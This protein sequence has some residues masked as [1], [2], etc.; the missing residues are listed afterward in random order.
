[1][2]SSKHQN[3]TKIS[4]DIIKEE[5]IKLDISENKIKFIK[6]TIENNT[7]EVIEDSKLKKITSWRKSKKK[8]LNNLIYNILSLG[9]LHI[10]SLFY[11]NLYLKLYCNPWPPKECDFFLVEN[12]YGELTLCTKIQKKAKNSVIDYNSEIIKQNTLSSSSIM[13][14]NQKIDYYLTKNLTYSFKYKSVI[15][16]Y[17]EET[18]EIIP[19][20]M[21]LSS[22]TKKGIFNYFSEG[23][24]SDNLVKKFQD[25][26]G[27]NEYNLN[28]DLTILYSKNIEIYYFIFI[29]ITKAF[30]LATLDYYSFFVSIFIIILMIL[31]EYCIMKKIVYDIYKKEYTLDGEGY[32]LR[33]KRKHKFDNNSNFYYEINNCELLPG[34]IIYL[35]AN[36]YVPCDC[37]ILEGECIVNES[38][39]TGKLDIYKKSNLENSNEQFNYNSNKI[40]ILYHGMKIVKTYSNLKEQYISALCINTGP[41]TY[42]A[43]QYSNILY[44]LERKV[45]YKKV[46]TLMGEGRKTTFIFMA[47]I[48]FFS[49]FLGLFYMYNV[50]KEFNIEVI[51]KLLFKIIAKL[52]TKSFMPVFYIT[53]T[54]IIMISII[55]LKNENIF[56][57][58]K[59][60]LLQS[61]TINT[62]FFGKT[63]T[64]CENNFEIYGYHPIYVNPHRSN[65]ITYTTFNLSQTKEMNSQLLNYYKYYLY[66]SQ[67]SNNPHESNLRHGF[68]LDNNLYKEKINKESYEYTALF[69]ECL[70]SCNNLEKY[71]IEI[72]GNPI[73]KGIFSNMRW[74]IKT[75]SFNNIKRGELL[76]DDFSNEMEASDNHYYFD[77]KFII[78][79][80]IDDIYPKNYY[81]ITESLKKDAE[82]HHKPLI[83]K[84]NSKYY[85]NQSKKNV[86]NCNSSKNASNS[87]LKS[88]NYIKINVSRSH[89]KSYKLRI[90]KRFISGNLNSSSIVYNFIT[91]ELRFMT[92]GM[93]EDILDKCDVNSLPD[94]FDKIISFYRRNGFIIIILA[95]KIINL[96]EYNDSNSIEDYMDDLT[97]C[98]FVTL[99]NKLKKEVINSIKDL[100]QFNCNLLI[101]TGDNVYN[102]LSVGFD[103]NII[104]NKNIF[105]FDKDESKNQLNI[106]KIFS[107]KKLSDNENDLK[108]TKSSFDKYSKQTSRLSNGFINSPFPLVSKK[109]YTAQKI[110][111][112][113]SIA[114]RSK[115]NYNDS[116]L[117]QNNHDP[118]NSDRKELLN[119]NNLFDK[120]KINLIKEVKYPYK[121]PKVM[122]NQK[123]S[124]II[125]PL[126]FAEKSKRNNSSHKKQKILLDNNDLQKLSNNKKYNNNPT[127][128]APSYVLE[129]YNYYPEIFEDHEEMADNCIY[130]M[131]G[132]AFSFLYKN[133]E[134]KHCKKLLESIYKFCKIYFSMSSLDK[135]LV[136][137]FYREYPENCICEIGECD[138]DFDSIMTSNIGINLREPKNRNTIL[139]HFY[140]ADSNILS[141]KKIIR[142]G[143]ALNENIM[144]LKISSVFYTMI[145][146]SYIFCCFIRQTEIISNQLNILEICF[147]IMSIS[148]FTTKY[149]SFTK[150]NPLIQNKKLYVYH[151]L[152]QIIGI[153]IIKFISIYVQCRFFIGNQYNLI[154]EQLD[155]IFCSYYFIFCIEQLISTI[156][157]FNLIS[158][159]RKS[160]FTNYFFI[161]F[162][163]ILFLYFVILETLNSSNYK[164]DFFNITIYEYLEEFVDSF[165]DRNK[166]KSLRAC[167]LDLAISIIYSRIIYLIFDKLANRNSK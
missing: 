87:S 107:V 166:L 84:L 93:P 43:N 70:L 47:I 110:N 42:K 91:K 147:L 158:F 46:Y 63:G 151:Y 92:K 150:S 124:K 117:V 19:V 69:I 131:S 96:D 114:K 56:C 149:D 145:L 72:F 58:D 129:S 64:L 77:K 115:V 162:N 22:M 27:K 125:S 52:L 156:F 8:F 140:A 79:K 29:L 23:L 142:E 141:L 35:K 24:S 26:Y 90:Y 55:N 32:K 88:Y 146:N 45:E 148:A 108:S 122:V 41:N 128:K 82:E 134:K 132:K 66:K 130:C 68:K 164:Y 28:N 121:T 31:L 60:R 163:L 34:D 2:P 78:N 51:K 21:N 167:M 20:Y 144:L 152:F 157:L 94:N 106:T 76:K 105:S 153:F 127:F 75:Y 40:N 101:S 67:N 86:Q 9:T 4:E 39:L 126:S 33:V 161:I 160:P 6:R 3:K 103:S 159:Y 113:N 11:P 116:F 85:F 102:T 119:K 137:D 18:D 5:E 112:H 123:N 83:T 74:D 138:S 25:R 118:D 65:K 99:K 62:I 10:I 12:I 1:M 104:E 36:D 89:I 135:S 48:F 15:Y 109:E 73:E 30:D 16:E 143:R 13:N 139:C 54:I 61:S 38:K 111:I 155:V 14:S 57:F 71:N 95:S 53:N 98:G 120:N 59:S 133:K 100:K 17:N 44:L 37:L 50:D 154:E 7:H 136:M 49:I 165:A 81:K 80:R 97:F